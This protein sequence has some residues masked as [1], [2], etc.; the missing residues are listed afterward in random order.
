[1]TRDI[2]ISRHSRNAVLIK[3]ALVILPLGVLIAFVIATLYVQD[4]IREWGLRD[5]QANHRLELAYELISRDLGRVRS[6]LL[7]AA[8]QYSLQNFDGTKTS[9]KQIQAEFVDFLK[10][11]PRFVQVRM[12]DRDGQEVIRVD[13]VGDEI[14]VIGEEDLQNKRDRYY[15][16][17][18]KRL[19][20]G[21]ILI[22]EFDLN[23]EHGVIEEPFVPVV[24]FVTPIGGISAEPEYLFVLNYLGSEL[25]NELGSISLPGK[26]LLI[27]DDGQYLIAPDAQDSWGWMIGHDRTFVKQFP[28]AWKQR[29]SRYHEAILTEEG[30]FAFRKIDLLDSPRMLNSNP[31]LRLDENEPSGVGKRVLWIVSYLP[32]HEVFDGAAQLL[33]R[34]IFFGL[35][36]MLPMFVLT[37]FWAQSAERRQRQAEQIR[38]SELKLRELSARL[39][40]IQEEERRTISREIH[41]DLGQKV[42]AINLD[43]KMAVRDATLSSNQHLNRAIQET[44]DLLTSLHDFAKR[45]RPPLL[46][47]FGF[48][49]AVRH[50]LSEVQQRLGLEVALVVEMADATIPH[51]VAENMF[52]VIQ[53]AINNVIK[54]SGATSTEVILRMNHLEGR[55]F[56]QVQIID[57]GC[58]VEILNPKNWMR[59]GSFLKD[60]RLGMLGMHERVELLGGTLSINS[61]SDQGTCVEA[62]VPIHD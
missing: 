28:S 9:Q 40:R 8:N 15:V 23:Q 55:E 13:K 24:R 25:L 34:L 37:R 48:V 38:A 49:E 44:D 42:T 47:D 60:G 5:S 51:V 50:H 27:R 3:Q 22:S 54:H 20:P 53:E 56:L 57:D 14:V 30:A 43:L 59:E 11:K 45:V 29:T 39:L 4:R 62:I 1:M 21:E 10:Y 46:D 32:P 31:A 7:L 36:T 12:I 33:R 18:S 52:R 26:T 35:L 58:G 19:A 2:D 17:E 16:Q 6:D 61:S 41:D